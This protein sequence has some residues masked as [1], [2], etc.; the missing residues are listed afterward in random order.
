MTNNTEHIYKSVYTLIG[1]I[2]KKYHHK[3]EIIS[4]EFFDRDIK[5]VYKKIYNREYA[6]NKDIVLRKILIKIIIYQN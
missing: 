5:R 1:G 4:S 2:I 3:I 6:N